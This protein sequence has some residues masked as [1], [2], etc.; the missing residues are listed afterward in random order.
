MCR[1]YIYEHPER[2]KLRPKRLRNYFTGH[3]VVCR[4]SGRFSGGRKYL[5]VSLCGQSAFDAYAIM[6]FLKA[7]P[8]ITRIN[9]DV[10]QR[11][12]RT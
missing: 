4:Y 6:N 5:Q 7:N 1:F 9:S 11:P 3:P 2:Y 10:K 12:V 8:E